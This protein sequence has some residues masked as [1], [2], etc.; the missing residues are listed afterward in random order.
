M[1]PTIKVSILKNISLT[2]IRDFQKGEY[3]DF[4]VTTNEYYKT[5]TSAVVPKS[6]KPGAWWA[7]EEAFCEA[8]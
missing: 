6:L 4:T 2:L 5:L 8:N 3:V 7:E 1:F